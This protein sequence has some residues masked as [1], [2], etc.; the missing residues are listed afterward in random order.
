M[1]GDDSSVVRASRRH[2]DDDHRPRIISRLEAHTALKRL[3]V[4]HVGLRLD[5][6]RTIASFNHGIPRSRIAL[7]RHRDLTT[8]MERWAQ[9]GFEA[10]EQR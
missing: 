10:L 8:Q 7:D 3:D 2:E 4:P 6:R 5:E 1:L 9:H